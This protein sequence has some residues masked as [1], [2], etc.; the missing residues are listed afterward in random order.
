MFICISLQIKSENLE[1]WSA[2]K[3]IL[4]LLSFLSRFEPIKSVNKSHCLVILNIR[5]IKCFRRFI[6]RK[7]IP[8]LGWSRFGGSKNG[9]HLEHFIDMYN[10]CETP[11][12]LLFI[13]KI[14]SRYCMMATRHFGG[15]RLK[16]FL[17]YLW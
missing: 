14:V 10:G 17:L 12:V 7:R 9:Y 8:Y 6:E 13:P 11:R 3:K 16:A 5:Q 15:M 2:C 4:R 1:F